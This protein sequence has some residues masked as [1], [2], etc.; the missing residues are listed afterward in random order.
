MTMTDFQASAARKTS[1][2]TGFISFLSSALIAAAGA[3][4]IATS[5]AII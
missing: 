3:L 1:G 2:D 5:F 4:L